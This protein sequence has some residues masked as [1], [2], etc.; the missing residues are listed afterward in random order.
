MSAEAT[1]VRNDLD[2]CSTSR[3]ASRQISATSTRR[4]SRE[5]H[6]GL[7]KVKDRIV[8]ISGAERTTN[9]KPDPV[10]GRTAGLGEDSLGKS[11]ARATAASSCA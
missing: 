3:G 2:G 6:Y 8:N 10:P 1:V 4:R 9:S 7:E 5:D 11:M